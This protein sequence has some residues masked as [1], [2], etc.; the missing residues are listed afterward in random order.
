MRALRSA[1]A[2]ALCAVLLLGSRAVPADA[3]PCPDGIAWPNCT[4]TSD[5]DHSQDACPQGGY[6]LV[7]CSDA[8]NST[9]S[10]GGLV[11]GRTGVSSRALEGP[12][13]VPREC[14][15]FESCEWTRVVLEGGVDGQGRRTARR[16]VPA[17][18]ACPRD[19][20]SVTE[21][22][23][24]RPN[25]CVKCP[26]GREWSNDFTTYGAG[27]YFE[28]PA[29]SPCPPGTFS[30]EAGTPC[31]P[32]AAGQISEPGQFPTLQGS[33]P[34]G[35]SPGGFLPGY[36]PS[37]GGAT[38]CTDC[39]TNSY[40][41]YKVPPCVDV[42]FKAPMS[43]VS[44]AVIGNATYKVYSGVYSSGV[45]VGSSANT[46]LKQV[47][48]DKSVGLSTDPPLH[49]FKVS[50]ASDIDD[51]CLDY[52]VVEVSAPGFETVREEWPQY[53]KWPNSDNGPLATVST[54]LV[55]V[56]APAEVRVVMQY[57]GSS[58]RDLKLFDLADRTN[59]CTLSNCAGSELTGGHAMAGGRAYGSFDG[60]KPV[61]TIT[62]Q[63]MT[64]GTIEVWVRAFTAFPVPAP[65][66]TVTVYC[67]D[68]QVMDDGSGAGRS[69]YAATVYQETPTV[70][71]YYTFWKA[72][73]VVY[74]APARP[75]WETCT[76]G[77]WG[78]DYPTRRRLGASSA[79]STDQQEGAKKEDDDSVP[80]VAIEG[81]TLD[82]RPRRIASPAR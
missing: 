35:V 27:T 71:S 7:P 17:C 21:P 68:C 55:P 41:E 44:Q 30:A 59:M 39:P 66:L 74:S 14:Q 48:L 19:Q 31:M 75:R 79:T 46:F 22:Y 52:G 32:C 56:L 15:G 72:G 78:T 20:E 54:P 1:A 60:S 61:E 8:A 50:S 4:C 13:A 10:D 16:W 53:M 77:C 34:G 64:S 24:E 36:T 38:A 40:P 76:T 6:C 63:G 58:D 11:C 3:I 80:S 51:A 67:H 37:F 81:S 26:A 57:M 29:C 25:K 43:A 45:G 18:V 69:G 28:G 62:M 70:S 5:F 2:L 49:T 23:T 33:P 82:E 12:T 42:M 73:Q 9:N 65:S 47:F